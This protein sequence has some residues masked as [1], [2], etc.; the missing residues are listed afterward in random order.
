MINWST[1]DT[2]LLDMDGTLLDL[3]F[4]NFFW[5]SHLPKRFTDIHG[6]ELAHVKGR[7]IDRIMSERGSLNWYCMDYWSQ[8]LD[9]NITALSVEVADKIRML[10]TTA[11]FL[12]ALKASGRDIWL[13]TNSHQDGLRIKLEKTGLN[14]WMHRIISSH[15]LSLPKEDRGFWP[16]LH[17]HWPFD[18]AKSLLI[19][20]TATVLDAAADFGVGQ[21]LTI[22]RPDSQS[23]PRPNLS[24]PA[25]NS[26]DDIMPIPQ[27]T[28]RQ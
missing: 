8:Q 27:R 4:D 20:D 14:T 26:F 7:L 13:V 1:I 23:P 19:D 11:R 12:D 25:L 18:P 24:Y 6:G 28:P 5:T 10:P 21:L 9:V 2:V 16:A 15:E 17:R 22:T 3:H